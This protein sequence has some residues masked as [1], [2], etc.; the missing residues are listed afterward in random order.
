MKKRRQAL[1]ILFLMPASVLVLFIFL[2]PFVYSGYISMTDW[3][4]ISREI[5]YIGLSNYI[6]IFK[7]KTIYEILRNNFIYFIEIVVFQNVLGVS[8]A[9]LLK[10]K[11]KG[12][13]FFRAALFLPT[14]VC[15]VAVGFVWNLL[16]DPTCGYIPAFF[17]KIGLDELA[18]IIW[19][20][21]IRTAIHVI[22]FVN[23][24]QWVGQTT[25][26]YLAGMMMVDDALYEAASIDGAGRQTK[27]FKIT[28]PLLAP[29]ITINLITATIGT[30]KIY[31]LPFTMTGGGPGH[32]T[33]SL[34][35]SIYTNSFTYNKMG[36]GTA[37]SLVLFLFV[38]IISILQMRVLHEREDAV[39]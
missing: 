11:F 22:S 25:V 20:G 35:I 30:L 8:I 21:D 12:R 31:D 18:S 2:V 38:L 29:S 15:T 33:E 3:N 24:W 19:L 14:V 13:N 1:P 17:S 34:A 26:I 9:A 23:I 4:G 6:S 36:Y 28:L 16:L 27:F 7:D 37:M 10:G 5:N 39:L 32:A